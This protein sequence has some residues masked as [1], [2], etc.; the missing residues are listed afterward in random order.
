[1]AEAVNCHFPANR[2]RNRKP[3]VHS[4][5]ERSGFHSITTFRFGQIQMNK[6]IQIISLMLMTTVAYADW[7]QSEN[8][9]PQNQDGYTLQDRETGEILNIRPN[10]YGLGVSSDQYGRAIKTDPSLR[11]TP[12]AYGPGI[13][14]DQFG[15]PVR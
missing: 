12:D 10:A 13:G 1:M 2:R 3:D 5:L 8:N 15:R 11:V 7:D 6:M 4:V 14:M 9:L